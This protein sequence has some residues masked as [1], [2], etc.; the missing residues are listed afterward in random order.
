[1]L[2]PAMLNQSLTYE[3][4]N[5]HM[6]RT[7][8]AF[9]KW[10]TLPPSWM[11]VGDGVSG[12]EREWIEF[13]HRTY[14]TLL[15]AGHRLQP[16]A[17]TATGVHPV[18]IGYGRVYVHLPNGFRYDDW[19]DGLRRGNSFVTTG[20]MLFVSISK[21]QVSAEVHADGA[22]DRIEVI[23]N[24][25]VYPVDAVRSTTK[26]D[27]SIEAT[28]S[29]PLDVTSTTWVAVRVWQKSA[30]GRLR[31]AHSAPQWID[32]ADKPLLP[33]REEKEFLVQRMISEWERSK[34]VLDPESSAEYEQAIEH[35]RALKTQH[36]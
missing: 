22:I 20:P 29:L 32:V 28:C 31:F 34:S 24:G 16:T 18:P 1:M 14:W 5:N 21:D 17:G 23:I 15:N 26:D 10:S 25:V 7:E 13:T 9:S 8:F 33:T 30:E 36:K 12:S 19:I 6:W 3:L 35:Y 4:A 11:N 2:L 27:G